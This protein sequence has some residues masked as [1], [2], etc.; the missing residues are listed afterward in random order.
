MVILAG[1]IAE[2]QGIYKNESFK[3]TLILKEVPQ[4]I[5]GRDRADMFFEKV[6][7]NL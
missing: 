4:R 5:I 7:Q 1:S 6:T 2:S 3:T